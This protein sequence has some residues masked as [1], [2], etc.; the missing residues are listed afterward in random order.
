VQGDPVSIPFRDLLEG[1]RE[2][3]PEF[4][5]IRDEAAAFVLGESQFRVGLLLY[6]Q[7]IEVDGEGPAVGFGLGHE[8]LL[9]VRVDKPSS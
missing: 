4:D 9:R 6:G 5:E 8:G 3:A 7:V 1:F 2:E